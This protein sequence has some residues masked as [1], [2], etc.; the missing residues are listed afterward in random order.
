M[1]DTET[2]EEWWHALLTGTNPVMPLRQ[3]RHIF[4]LIPGHVRCKFCNA[5]FDGRWASLLR[6]IGRGQSRLTA[7]FCQQCQ[8]IA[9]KH[10]GGAEVE[11][12]LLF[13]DVRGSTKLGELMKPA[14]FSQLI[15][16]FFSVS[17]HVL[18]YTNA[19]VDR[20]VGDQVIGIYIPYFVG[21]HHARMAL[22][23][24][25]DLLH[26][27]GNDERGEPWIQVGVGIHSGNAFIGTVGSFTDG[28]TDIT[29]LGDV[30]NVAARLASAA[31]PG[32]ILISED[33]SMNAELPATL[34]TR[35]LDLKGKSQPMIVHI[36]KRGS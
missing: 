30:P 26:A 6:L 29:V 22:N 19:W 31:G 23:A 9:T 7:Q 28:V 35:S 15:G 27:T 36:L 32:E 12:T 16:R 8:A 17:S 4:A 1:K 5:P 3:V 21:T 14:E 13:A 25:Q 20:L 24:A 2:A 33:A 10:I 18:L 34:E 11:L